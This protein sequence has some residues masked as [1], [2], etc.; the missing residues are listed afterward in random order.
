MAFLI[1]GKIPAGKECV[2][3]SQ[4]TIKKEGG[5]H[6]EGVHSRNEFSCGK[7]RF[8]DLVDIQ[9]G[10]RSRARDSGGGKLD[11]RMPFMYTNPDTGA[12]FVKLPDTWSTTKQDCT[13]M[14]EPGFGY[15]TRVPVQNNPESHAGKSWE[16]SS[17][18]PDGN[19]AAALRKMQELWAGLDF[20]GGVV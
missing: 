18:G 13:W 10:I 19:R 14:A 7:A 12:W 4:C 9:K 17:L 6:H 1:N 5:C 3:T 20:S 16:F 8:F 2:Y 11:T 15:F